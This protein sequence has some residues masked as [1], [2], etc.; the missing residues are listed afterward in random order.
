VA[1]IAF[2]KASRMI[3]L[4][5]TPLSEDQIRGICEGNFIMRAIIGIFVL[6]DLISVTCRRFRVLWSVSL[7]PGLIGSI[8]QVS[9][10]LKDL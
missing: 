7:I 8:I 10:L 5:K 9:P 6:A 4:A 3:A 1:G 2:E